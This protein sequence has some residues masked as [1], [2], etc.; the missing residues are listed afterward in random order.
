VL[1]RP[2]FS[3]SSVLGLVPATV[4]AA[5]TLGLTGCDRLPSYQGPEL[6]AFEQLQHARCVSLLR[7]TWQGAPVRSTSAE[8]GLS[9]L[10]YVWVNVDVHDDQDDIDRR[11]AKG[12]AHAGH[13]QF[14][15]GGDVVHVH[16]YALSGATA[17]AAQTLPATAETPTAPPA[18]SARSV[19]PVQGAEEVSAYRYFTASV[20]GSGLPPADATL[21]SN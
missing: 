12:T 6:S 7:S 8:R 13:C 4:L 9:G 1:S 17:A 15:H 16:S 3:R 20:K 5:L 18:P 10:D 21:A 11:T 2:L 14:D 19:P